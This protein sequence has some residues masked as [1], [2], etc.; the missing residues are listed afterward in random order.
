MIDPTRGIDDH[1]DVWIADGV[2]ASVGDAPGSFPD[3]ESIDATGLVICPGLVDL[4]ARLREPGETHKGC[5]ASETRAGLAS[6]ITTLCQP[7]DTRPVI[8]A[9]ATV[10]LIHQRAVAA[11]AARVRPVG[12]LT[13]GLSGEYLAPMRA[14]AA[15]GCVALGQ[16]NRPVR[17]TQVLRQALAYA[18]THELTVMLPP[19]DPDLAHGCAHEGAVATRLGL[20]GIPVAAETVGLARVIALAADTGARIHVGRIS[21]AA[22]CD[23]L[24][25][26][27][28]A[29]VTISADVAAHQL[30]LTEDAVARF[31]SHA[32]VQPPLRTEGDRSALRQAVGEGLIGTV[33]SDH[34]PHEADAK[35]APFG[36][37]AAGISA[38][39]SLLPLTLDLAHAGDCSLSTAVGAL[40]AG[41]AGSLGLTAGNLAAGSPADLCAF[42]P[43]AEWA[44]DPASMRSRGRNTPF[45][46]GFM[47]GR[48]AWC[49]LDGRRV[50]PDDIPSEP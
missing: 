45:A 40:T 24:A 50:T 15:A 39:E 13:I 7:P 42:D 22:A 47:K 20:P 8:D 21:S 36:A 43:D 31:D 9:P 19:I 46:N 3:H 34:Q 28:A 18:A 44:L 48:V 6:G 49:V 37:S 35:R 11:D 32:R 16:A 2:I 5:I 27:R 29:G 1:L 4:C 30:H 26:A 23:L 33:C 38:L 41:P 14:L 10:E 17:D 12:A 25:R